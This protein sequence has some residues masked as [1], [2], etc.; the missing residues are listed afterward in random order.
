MKA[1]V[2]ICVW[3]LFLPVGTTGAV[4]VELGD[5]TV[6]VLAELEDINGYLTIGYV[7]TILHRRGYVRLEK[8]RVVEVALQTDDELRLARESREEALRQ[9]RLLEEQERIE[10]LEALEE[11]NRV[12]IAEGRTLLDEKLNSAAFADAPVE[13]RFVFLQ[14]FRGLYPEI[15]ID[16]LYDSTRIEYEDWTLRRDV[17][18]LRAQVRSLDTL[19]SEGARLRARV[20]DL[21]EQIRSHER[22]QRENANLRYRIDSLENRLQETDADMTP[23]Q[24]PADDSQVVRHTHDQS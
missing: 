20:A 3:I 16:S 14:E 7:T 11:A 13:E 10:R 24:S 22:V 1:L 5:S 9:A 2:A 23:M 12:R 6:R 18:G 17:E 21:E 4:A 8:G 19:R 15:P